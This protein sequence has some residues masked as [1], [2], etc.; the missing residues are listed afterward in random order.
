MYSGV[1]WIWGQTAIISQYSINWLVCIT[2]TE[3]VYCAVRAE[4]LY[5]ASLT[6][7]NSTFCPH[8]VFMCFVWIWEQTAIISLYI[9]N[10]LV[11]ITETE[12]V[13]C[14]VR[15]GSSYT[16]RFNIHSSTFC[17]HSIFRCSVWIWE[18]TAIISLYIIN[19]LVCI[20]ETECVYCAVRTGS[21]YIIQ[22]MCLCGF[23]NKQRLFPY[24]A[25]TDWGL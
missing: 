7:S 19:W 9:I 15:T 25:L 12:C 17:P 18:Q 8:S 13:Y 23:E 5:I 14:V 21:L 11:C 20:T 4:S 10:R 1:V 2:E 6:F 22:V 24:T 3:C 16:A